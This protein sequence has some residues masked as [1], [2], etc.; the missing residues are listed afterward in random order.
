MHSKE[1]ERTT[2]K[3]FVIKHVKLLIG[4]IIL[5]GIFTV[6]RIYHLQE[7][8]FFRHMNSFEMCVFIVWLKMIVD[9]MVKSK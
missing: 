7:F 2:F 9:W 1:I 5:L 8:Y 4:V 3:T 6:G